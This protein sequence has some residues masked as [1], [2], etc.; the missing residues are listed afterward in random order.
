[1]Q[2]DRDA[3]LATNAKD[4]QKMSVDMSRI[5]DKHVFCVYGNDAKIMANKS[6]FNNLVKLQK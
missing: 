4:I 1:V 6:L 3:V 2:T 5:I